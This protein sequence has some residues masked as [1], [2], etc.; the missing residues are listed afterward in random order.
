MDAKVSVI[1]TVVVADV[2]IV[3]KFIICCIVVVVNSVVLWHLGCLCC[4]HGYCLF[5]WLGKISLIYEL[6]I[7]HPQLFGQDFVVNFVTYT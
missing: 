7:S 4:F 2:I 1:F 5:W 6:V 3:I